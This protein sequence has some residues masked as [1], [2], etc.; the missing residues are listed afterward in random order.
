MDLVSAFRELIHDDYRLPQAAGQWVIQETGALTQNP[1]VHIAAGAAL[2][3]TLDRGGKNPLAFIKENTALVGMRSFCDAV[4]V[5]NTESVPVVLHRVGH[6]LVEVGARPA[7]Q[8]HMVSSRV[9]DQWRDVKAALGCDHRA[10]EVAGEQQV[11]APTED[12]QRR[13]TR[14]MGDGHGIGHAVVDHIMVALLVD[15]KRIFV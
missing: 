2:G 13:L 10:V 11:A 4:L 8:Q 14:H 9:I 6:H 15:A 1:E 5:C 3:F 7:A 12:E